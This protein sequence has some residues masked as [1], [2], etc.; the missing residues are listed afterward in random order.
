MDG[1]YTPCSGKYFLS[2]ACLALADFFQSYVLYQEKNV[3]FNPKAG[4]STSGTGLS[5]SGTRKTP[6]GRTGQTFVD[7]SSQDVFVPGSLLH[8]KS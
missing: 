2:N 6:S 5:R 8:R 1:G 4:S 7:V 3:L